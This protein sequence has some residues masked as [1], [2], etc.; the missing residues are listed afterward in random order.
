MKK[1]HYLYLALVVISLLLVSCSERTNPLGF[2]KINDRGNG[3]DGVYTYPRA[4]QECISDHADWEFFNFTESK[5][6]IIK[7]YAPLGFNPF[8]PGEPYP[9]LYLLHDFNGDHN[10]Y[11]SNLVQRVA[12]SLIYLEEIK[13]FYIATVDAS[14]PYGGSWYADNEFF[15]HFEEM[16]TTDLITFIEEQAGIP[17][18]QKRS[19]RAIGGFGMGGYGAL[20]LAAK[21]PELYSAVSTSNC[22]GIFDFN[23]TWCRDLAANVFQELG[24]STPV[25]DFTIAFDTVEINYETPYTML[26]LSM[27]Q[28]FSPH[29]L[30]STHANYELLKDDTDTYLAY[31]GV[32]LPFDENGN[33]Y[34]AVWN[35]WLENDLNA[36]LTANADHFD[37]LEVYMEYS[38]VNQFQFNEMAQAVMTLCDQ[39]GIDY[40]SDSYVGYDGYDATGQRFVY[41]RLV[42]ILKFH[43]K[44]LDHNP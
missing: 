37:S 15:G 44:N 32:H 26:A 7:Y 42:E 35:L 10:F 27:A 3:N 6:F 4:F 20:K 11:F 28:A 24:L 21:H 40:R 39:L 23:D 29:P 36:V 12:D 13:P 31:L 17:V 38:D 8:I 1:L 30:D 5:N 22:A 33:V 18:I 25:T 16:H 43:S 41:D 9:I 2:P 19:S 34:T 14:T